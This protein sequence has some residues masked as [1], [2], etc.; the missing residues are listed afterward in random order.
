MTLLT[1]Y[2]S[3]RTEALWLGCNTTRRGFSLDCAQKTWRLEREHHVDWASVRKV[4][5]FCQLSFYIPLTLGSCQLDSPR[6]FTNAET[7]KKK[8]DFF[9]AL[10]LIFLVV[11][12]FGRRSLNGTSPL[13][14]GWDRYYIIGWD[15]KRSHCVFSDSGSWFLILYFV[16][17][18]LEG[19]PD[20]VSPSSF[21]I[22]LGGRRWLS[23]CTSPIGNYQLTV[24]TLAC[25]FRYKSNSILAFTPR[26][27]SRH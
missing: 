16:F 15:E 19:V 24:S 27:N 3:G 12:L 5:Q 26:D 22:T 2:L 1:N 13:V 17:R 10:L 11:F 21:Y 14:Y 4:E 8:K 18:G 23:L 25:R 20:V 7:W 9:F 6:R